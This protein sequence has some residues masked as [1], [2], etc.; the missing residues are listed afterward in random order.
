MNEVNREFYRWRKV[1]E[2]VREGEV[3]EERF[4]YGDEELLADARAEKSIFDYL[5]AAPPVAAAPKSTGDEDES[6]GVNSKKTKEE[7]KLVPTRV[8]A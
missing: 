8:L 5:P 7:T 1:S 6:S 4:V 3:G 2:A